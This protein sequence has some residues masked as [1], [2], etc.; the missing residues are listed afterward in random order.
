[1][2]YSDV[3][4][5]LSDFCD[6]K[7]RLQLKNTCKY[8]SNKI[9]L[10]LLNKNSIIDVDFMKNTDNMYRLFEYFRRRYILPYETYPLYPY[11]LDPISYV[12][13]Q[14]ITYAR[15]GDELVYKMETK[16]SLRAFYLDIQDGWFD[17]DEEYNIDKLWKN[18]FRNLTDN[19]ECSRIF[20][21]EPTCSRI[22]GNEYNGDFF[23]DDYLEDC[24]II[25]Y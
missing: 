24:V 7:T 4:I 6:F 20:G 8:L 21:V 16:K 9:E 2:L 25:E 14:Q 11:I 17:F 23:G 19:S 12:R 3:L 18:I 5:Y 1:M 10:N 15:S 22:N 13:K